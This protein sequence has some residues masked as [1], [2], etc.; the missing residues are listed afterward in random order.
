[1]KRQ[2]IISGSRYKIITVLNNSSCVS[3]GFDN[4]NE[5]RAVLLNDANSVLRQWRLEYHSNE[6]AYKM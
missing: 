5:F 6:Q 1:M 4:D 3:L 2:E